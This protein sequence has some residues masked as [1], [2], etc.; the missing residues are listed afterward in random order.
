M[1]NVLLV[2]MIAL[3][4]NFSINGIDSQSA[5][6]NIGNQ[7]GGNGVNSTS[8]PG[9]GRGNPSSSLNEG[10]GPERKKTTFSKTSYTLTFDIVL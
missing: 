7:K 6:P 2:A 3:A 10:K 1:N 5:K 9:S 4:C 8:G